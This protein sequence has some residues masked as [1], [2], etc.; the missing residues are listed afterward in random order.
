MTEL[1]RAPYADAP[2]VFLDAD[3]IVAAAFAGSVESAAFVVL[4]LGEATIL[5][6]VTSQQVLAEVTRNIGRLLPSRTL[7]AETIIRRACR[8]VD[9]PLPDRVRVVLDW[10]HPK[11]AP[12]LAAALDADCPWLVTFN[13][14]HFKPPSE[15]MA[16][17][18]PGAFLQRLRGRLA[19]WA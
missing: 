19:G 3:A 2:R 1:P 15:R 17:M 13:I 18:T 16:V 4:L 11:D 6:C 12:I 9:D 5:D 7:E 8:I 10:A 14:R